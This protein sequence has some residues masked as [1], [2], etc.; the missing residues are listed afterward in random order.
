MTSKLN[1]SLFWHWSI[2]WL[3]FTEDTE[4][5]SQFGNEQKYIILACI[6]I[7]SSPITLENKEIYSGLNLPWDKSHYHKTA[8]PLKSTLDKWCS[9]VKKLVLG[10][11]WKYLH[12]H[13][14][15][16]EPGNDFLAILLKRTGAVNAC[17]LVLWCCEWCPCLSLKDQRSCL[18]HICKKAGRRRLQWLEK[19]K[20][21]KK[22]IT[23]T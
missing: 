20:K 23:I 11:A 8:R 13:G 9:T 1:N 19:R 10:F 3:H 15:R 2:F 21:E 6:L 14:W 12:L 17:E 7:S 18:N 5:I 16:R 4:K 22:R